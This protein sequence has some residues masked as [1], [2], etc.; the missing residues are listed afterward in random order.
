MN[1]TFIVV[2]SRGRSK[3]GF[4]FKHFKDLEHEIILV[5]NRNEVND[6]RQAGIT[7]LVWEHDLN[8]IPSIRNFILEKVGIG[9]NVIVMDDDIRSFGKFIPSGKKNLKLQISFNNFLTILK[10]GFINLPSSVKFFGVSPTTN[11]LN[12]NP[13]KPISKNV[14]ILGSVQCIRVTEGLIYDE[15]LPLKADYAFTAENI[16]QGFTVARFN[17]LYADNDFD[18]LPG[19]RQCYSKGESDKMLSFEYLLRKYP[20]YFKPNP[21][22]KYEL[23]MR[24]K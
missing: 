21:N 17:Y 4:T 5:V 6:Y 7:N 2:M 16:K 23:I 1:K 15:A 3:T 18:K 20:D 13:K 19:G 10:N 11:P 14:F 22:R 9:N 12:Y 8:F 24:V